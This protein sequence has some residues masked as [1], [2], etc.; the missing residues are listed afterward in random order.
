MNRWAKAGYRTLVFG[1]RDLSEDEHAEFVKEFQMANTAR[2]G[3]KGKRDALFARMERDL[4]LVGATAVEDKLQD[5][6]P[7]T[8]AKLRQGNVRF[9]MCTGDK[10]STAGTIAK[11][12]KLLP[13]R[14]DAQTSSDTIPPLVLGGRDQAA[15]GARLRELKAQLVR[16]GYQFSSQLPGERTG[17][18]RIFGAAW[19][20]TR[21]VGAPDDAAAA[22]G[23]D[24]QQTQSNPL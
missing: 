1:Y 15:V 6:V 10:Q 9:W 22:S 4:I 18:L 5:Q 14:S 19:C 24:A 21:G 16:D 7:E 23:P 17:L 3:R 20:G 2:D 11:T 12:C 8:I 13:L